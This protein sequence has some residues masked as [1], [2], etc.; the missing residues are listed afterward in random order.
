MAFCGNCGTQLNDGAKFCPKCGQPTSEVSNVQNQSANSNFDS[1]PEKQIKTW[2]KIVSV[3]FWPAGAIITIAAFLKKQQALAKSAL[4]YTAIGIALAIVISIAGSKEEG[5]G[6]STKTENIT[7]VDVVEKDKQSEQSQE[8]TP[9]KEVNPYANFVGQYKLYDESSAYDCSIKVVDDG[10]LFYNSTLGGENYKYCGKITPM[11]DNV[12]KILLKEAI[13]T[14]VFTY[15]N[16]QQCTKYNSIHLTEFK[17][18][19]FDLS[20]NKMY[21]EKEQYENRDFAQP[22]YYKFRFTKK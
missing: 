2:Q 16:N 6:T 10:R 17:T 14:G 1:E 19:I 4:L 13:Y 11:S 8:E 3:L 5:S 7:S 15:K 9:K 18:L 22:E 21:F 20:D 12:F